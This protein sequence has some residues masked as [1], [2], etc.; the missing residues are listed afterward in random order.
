M[1]IPENIKISK[2]KFSIV[3]K[4]TYTFAVGRMTDRMELRSIAKYS[5]DS[6]KKMVKWLNINILAKCVTQKHPMKCL[7][8]NFDY[9]RSDDWYSIEDIYYE[10]DKNGFFEI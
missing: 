1:T 8:F 2:I 10:V 6:K 4:D 9:P 3:D 5:S 7:R